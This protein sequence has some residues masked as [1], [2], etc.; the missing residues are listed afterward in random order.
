M[1][2]IFISYKKEERDTAALLA[3]RLTAAGYD[4]WWDAALLAGDRFEDEIAS[5]LRASGAVI[6]LWSKLAVASDWVKAEAESARSQKKVLPATIDDVAIDTLPLLFRGLHV[7]RLRDWTGADDHPGYRELMAAVAERLGEAAGPHLSVPQAEAKLAQSADEAEVW[8]AI[9]SN[10]HPNADEYRAYLRRYGPT[11]R[12]ADLAELRVARIEREEK[13]EIAEKAVPPP[14]IRRRW[15]PAVVLPLLALVVIAVSG[16]WLWS[17]GDLPF[18]DEWLNTPRAQDAT[19]CKNWASGAELQ[20]ETTLPRS[21]ATVEAACERAVAAFPR[22]GDYKGMLAAMRIAQGPQYYAD[23]LDLAGQGTSLGGGVAELVTGIMYSLGKG[24]NAN[25]S[26]AADHFKAAA[27]KNQVEA[28]ARLC[29]LALD[30][31][32]PPYEATWDDVFAYCSQASDAGN[33][34]GLAGMGYITEHGDFDLAPDP[35]KAADYYERAVALGNISAK[36]YLAA[37]LFN[38]VGVARDDTRAVQLFRDGDAAGFPQA[39]RWLGVAYELGQGVPQDTVEAGLYYEDAYQ[40]GDFAVRPLIGFSLGPDD[41][42]FFAKRDVESMAGHDPNSPVFQRI[43]G[44]AAATGYFQPVDAELGKRQLEQ[45]AP[46][47]IFCGM[48]LGFFLKYGP[49]QFNDLAR[50]LSLFGAAAA[51][52]ELHAQYEMGQFYELGQGVEPDINEALRYYRMA[53]AQGSGPARDRI[54]FLI[55]R[56]SSSAP[57]SS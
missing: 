21:N 15:L 47:N 24:V 31:H 8:S 19:T 3:T 41:P 16:S 27:A 55:S 30:F 2:D 22:N 1:P 52:G 11:A 53:A 42:G 44:I 5:V 26:V 49:P 40:R 51:A 48:A 29:W 28:A 36:I 35:A 57:S 33:P 37:L 54:D 10:P 56:A 38:G 45:C 13:E 39:M 14:P 6:V 50:A 34:L 7:V 20:W 23:A 46:G 12:F 25:F 43:S 4:V 9:A 32:T 18:I 17:R